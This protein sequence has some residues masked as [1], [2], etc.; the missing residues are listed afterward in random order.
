MFAWCQ[1]VSL[2]DSSMVTQICYLKALYRIGWWWCLYVYL[3]TVLTLLVGT[4]HAL[5]TKSLSTALR[6]TTLSVFVPGK[7]LLASVFLTC[8]MELRATSH[9]AIAKRTGERTGPEGKGPKPVQS[10]G[11]LGLLSARES[12]PSLSSPELLWREGT[13]LRASGHS[14]GWLREWRSKADRKTAMVP[15]SPS[16][17]PHILWDKM[18]F[19]LNKEK[20]RFLFFPK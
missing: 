20:W 7:L 14:R 15:Q 4:T 17:T 16:L 9:W 10:E 6:P 12:S 1:I 18:P 2:I 19:Y 3:Y 13:L 8:E 11:L 5:G